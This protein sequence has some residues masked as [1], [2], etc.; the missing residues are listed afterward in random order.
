MSVQSP[1]Q[2]GHRG[3]FI[4]TQNGAAMFCYHLHRFVNILNIKKMA[5]F[6]EIPPDRKAVPSI[7]LRSCW[8]PKTC[9]SVTKFVVAKNLLGPSA[10]GLA[11]EPE[12]D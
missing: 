7:T 11:K 4:R 6:D 2:D 3:V 12:S 5:Q 9:F 10:E 8:S 1:Q